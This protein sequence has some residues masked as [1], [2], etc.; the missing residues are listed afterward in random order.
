[1]NIVE[2]V[3]SNAGLMGTVFVAVFV[4][5][6]FANV[7]SSS[8]RFNSAITTAVILVAV[9]A[10]TLFAMG[11][12]ILWQPL[13][14]AAALMFAVAYLGNVLTFSSSVVNALVTAVIFMVP[15]ILGMMY[16]TTGSLPW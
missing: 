2:Y 15:F 3:Q 14:L 8:S 9:I 12:E 5:D 13:A 6:Y 4:I 7:M 1:M 10:A 11:E 16:L